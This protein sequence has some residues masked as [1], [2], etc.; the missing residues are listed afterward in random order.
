MYYYYFLPQGDK[1]N[2]ALNAIIPIPAVYCYCL[3]RI[4]I[5]IV[6]GF[7]PLKQDTKDCSNVYT[8]CHLCQTPQY[9]R[10]KIILIYS[11]PTLQHSRLI[12]DHELAVIGEGGYIGRSMIFTSHG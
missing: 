2:D 11:K 6:Y 12:H 7:I 9:E 5:Q 10:K 4:Q 8:L 1:R 3:Y